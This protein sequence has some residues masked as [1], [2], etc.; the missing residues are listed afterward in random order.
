M[1]AAGQ[2][3]D[4]A[5]FDGRLYPVMRIRGPEDEKGLLEMV[6]KRRTT[7]GEW[8]WRGSLTAPRSCPPARQHPPPVT[9][10][11]ES[12]AFGRP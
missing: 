12:G 9:S 2:V 1:D 6:S 4:S 7:E 5:G 3:P 8:L 11:P 10:F